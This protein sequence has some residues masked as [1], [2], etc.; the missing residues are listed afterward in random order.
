MK[1]IATIAAV[2]TAA[3]V[4]APLA[5]GGNVVATANK[6]VVTQIVGTQVAKSH[7]AHVAIALQRHQVQVAQ[8]KRWA[9]LRAQV[10]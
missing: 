1:R 3:A 2:V 9:L 4:T 8:A 6:Q 10:R 5:A 7:R